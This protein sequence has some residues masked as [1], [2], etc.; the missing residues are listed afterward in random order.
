MARKRTER[1]HLLGLIARSFYL[2]TAWNYEFLQALGFAYVMSSVGRRVASGGRAT[3]EFLERH[4]GLFNTNP[5]LASYIIG[6]TAR[7]E[8]RHSRGETSG[9]EI[10][11]LKSALAVPLAAVGDRFFWA[12]LRPLS[13]LLGILAAGWLGAGGALVLLAV[14]NV[15]HLY[16]R[17]KGVLRGYALGAGLVSEI[18]RLR[19]PRLTVHVGWIGAFALGVL[20]VTA[21]HGWQ[22][23]WK[24]EAVFVL[25]SVALAAG[26]LP[27]FLR[28][29]VTEVA[30]A[31][32]A[33]GLLLTAGGLLG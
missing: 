18:S 31:L 3:R 32:G 21:V 27:Q 9:A 1:R 26:F 6:G 20:M 30:L 12:G 15:F 7:L 2:Q 14:Y 11:A 4:T 22:A 19:L 16:Y 33:L 25:P 8:E 23:A 24:R 28:T 29:R 17:V 5:V 10:V 13:G